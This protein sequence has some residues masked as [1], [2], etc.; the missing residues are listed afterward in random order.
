MRCA[1]FADMLALYAGGDL[2]APE[3][4]QVREHLA[5]CKACR[6]RLEGLREG[7]AALNRAAV[8]EEMLPEDDVAYWHEVE[9]KLRGRELAVEQLSSSGSWW[10][11]V[12]RV[13]A[14]AAVVLAA[15]GAVL[16]FTTF[17][18]LPVET[19]RPAALPPVQ[20]DQQVYVFYRH[21]SPYQ[22]A[23]RTEVYAVPEGDNEVSYS[24]TGHVVRPAEIRRLRQLILPV[25]VEEEDPSRF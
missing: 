9:G 18:Q 1:S 3:A 14:Q 4:E 10:V 25:A 17:R 21:A 13:L 11:R 12:P 5:H 2:A 22:Q 20:A 8:T 19:E 7:I 24:D 15:A 16:W 6:T 23:A